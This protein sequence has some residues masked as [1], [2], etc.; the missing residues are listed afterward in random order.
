MSNEKKYYLFEGTEEVTFSDITDV[1]RAAVKDG[2][3]LTDSYSGPWGPLGFEVGPYVLGSSEE[4]LV[5]GK[6]FDENDEE[7]EGKY[8]YVELTEEEFTDYLD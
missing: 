5:I 2:K 3:G 6:K 7:N 4:N 1:Y 8:T